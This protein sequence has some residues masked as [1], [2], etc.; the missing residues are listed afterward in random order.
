MRRLL[1]LVLLLFIIS[2][3]VS[4]CGLFDPG[5]DGTRPE[6]EY[7]WWGGFAGG[8]YE[9]L[10]ISK[11]GSITKKTG[12][13]ELTLSLS[14]VEHDSIFTLVKGILQYPTDR[15]LASANV[16]DDAYF[17]I[18]IGSKEFRISEFFLREH[19]DD[20]A[21]EAAGVAIHTLND[22]GSYTYLQCAPWIGLV[23]SAAPS[24]TVYT[25]G[26]T[27]NVI[28]TLN[29][30]TEKTRSLLFRFQYQI[31]LTVTGPDFSGT[32]Y[33]FPS[34]TQELQEWRD[35]LPPSKI[36]LEP[37]ES[38]QT[39]YSWPQPYI[40]HHEEVR[41]LEP[42]IYQLYM[43][44]LNGNLGLQNASIEIIDSPNPDL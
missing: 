12:Y 15:F 29:N 38:W 9:D 5:D 42:G 31:R 2:V 22:L 17:D 24:Q 7:R 40:D 4:N 43:R 25:V 34:S 41:I 28:Y 36:T 26:D 13:P 23:F 19:G 35:N 3:S 30:P 20:P 6:V 10:V 14:A 39:T 16:N 8:V 32:W 21:A 1:Q 11:E 18:R 33:V 37:G 27:I 44:M